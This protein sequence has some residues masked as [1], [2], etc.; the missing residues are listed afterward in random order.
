[1][2][3]TFWS[4][5]I[6]IYSGTFNPSTQ[7]IFFFCSLTRMSHHMRR[8]CASTNSW[9]EKKKNKW[10]YTQK[11]RQ[12]NAVLSTKE[13]FLLSQKRI[14]A[15]T[16]NGIQSLTWLQLLEIFGI[17]SWRLE[18][19]HQSNQEYISTS[20]PTPLLWM[21]RYKNAMAHWKILTNIFE[22]F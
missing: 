3:Q 13:C 17:F 10:K 14:H 7:F 12:T 22:I 9:R 19:F 4:I 2:M 16:L 5:H 15:R 18:P 6:I 1:M 20:S 8:V 21:R 11:K